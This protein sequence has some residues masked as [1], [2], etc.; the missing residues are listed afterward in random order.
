MPRIDIDVSVYVA[1]NKIE[2]KVLN[3][4]VESLGRF[5]KAT[6]IER[7]G[8]TIKDV[9]AKTGN[10]NFS[11]K[12]IQAYNPENLFVPVSVLNDL[13]RRLYEKTGTAAGQACTLS[14]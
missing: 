14:G 8:Q 9:F 1:K 11:L 2:A 3:W 12:T 4:N 10:T 5:D 13:R 7:V 6:Y